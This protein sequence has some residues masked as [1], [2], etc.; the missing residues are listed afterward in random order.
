VKYLFSVLVVLL[1]GCSPE[2][3]PQHSVTYG[4]HRVWYGGDYVEWTDSNGFG[5]GSV[6]RKNDGWVYTAS[7]ASRGLNDPWHS[8][9]YNSFQEAVTDVEKWCK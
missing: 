2:L 3:N 9:S 8:V 1:V 4:T 6:K 7:L 5:C